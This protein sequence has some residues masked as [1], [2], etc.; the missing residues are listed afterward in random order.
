MNILEILCAPIFRQ[1]EQLLIFRSKFSEIAQLPAI[2][3]QNIVKGV[4]EGWVETGMSWLE[5]DGAG[6]RLK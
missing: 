6:W 3:G 4:T 1:N 2:L 5:V